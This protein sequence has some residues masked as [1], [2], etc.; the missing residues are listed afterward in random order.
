MRIAICS[1][2]FGAHYQKGLKRLAAS[3]D[4]H[5][6]SWGRMFYTELPKGWPSH[7]AKPYA[8]KHH[9]LRAAEKAG[10]DGAVWCD[11]NAHVVKETGPWEQTC[12]QR[13][14]TFAHLGWDVGTWCTD[15]AL[16]R[17][18]ITR[19]VAFLIPMV[20]AA[21]YALRFDA[22]ESQQ[23]LEYLE[24]HEDAFAGPW[25]NASNLASQDQR[26]R[27]HRHDQTVLSVAIWRYALKMDTPPCWLDYAYNDGKYPENAIV[28][29]EGIL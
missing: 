15:S 10:Y 24:G 20:C 28:V 19:D 12:I 6:S 18:G 26:V 21:V 11:A 5:G 7:E 14:Y 16:D 29:K 27:G 2:G 17:L 22:P 13:G 25:N 3:L 23:V 4:K 1:A 9:A 8:F